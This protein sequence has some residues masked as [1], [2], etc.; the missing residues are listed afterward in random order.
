[1]Q[2][3]KRKVVYITLYEIIAIAMSSAGL[4]LL[5]AA[6]LIAR[7]L[8]AGIDQFHFAVGAHNVVRGQAR[9]KTGL[10]ADK[11]GLQSAVDHGA[12]CQQKVAVAQ[13]A[14]N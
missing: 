5:Y 9:Q 2:G 10:G 1:M 8:G 6:G 11:F 4:A 3:I 14:C 7:E 12:L 13:L